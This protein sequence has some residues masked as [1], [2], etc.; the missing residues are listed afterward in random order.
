MVTIICGAVIFGF[1][2]GFFICFWFYT[3]VENTNKRESD[4]DAERREYAGD[5][6]HL[7]GDETTNQRLEDEPCPN[8]CKSP[9]Q[10]W[11]RRNRYRNAEQSI[12]CPKRTGCDVTG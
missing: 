2:L 8:G 10:D 4:H 6:Q 12:Q 1:F 9:C 3:S 7:T 5:L 11:I